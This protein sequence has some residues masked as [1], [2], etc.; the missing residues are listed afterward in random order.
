MK[1]T[2]L[3]AW[4]VASVEPRA[5]SASG[6]RRLHPSSRAAHLTHSG[7]AAATFVSLVGALAL[8]AGTLSAAA[9]QPTYA[10][11]MHARALDSFRQGRF[12]EAYGRFVDLAN[13]GHPASARYALW[14]CE[15]GPAL[16]GKEWDCAPHEAED[17]ARAAGVVSPQVAGGQPVTQTKSQRHR[18]R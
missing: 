8:L 6:R 15:Q 10:E 16:F 7:R 13:T 9:A 18:S 14:M 2:H 4:V 17:W 5:C 1:N 12:P 11:R 3:F